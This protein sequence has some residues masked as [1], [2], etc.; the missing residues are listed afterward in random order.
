MNG[1]RNV[2]HT[3]THTHTHTMEYYSA[4]K[5]NKIM[6]FVLGACVQENRRQLGW[7]EVP[8]LQMHGGD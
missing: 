4:M 7:Y 8:S 6:P 5:K 1:K 3:Q 2:T